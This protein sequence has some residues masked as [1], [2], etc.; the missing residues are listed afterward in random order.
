MQLI[1]T[2]WAESFEAGHVGSYV[3]EMRC[4][5]VKI[6]VKVLARFV[7]IRSEGIS[8]FIV[9]A[10][11]HEEEVG[12]LFVCSVAKCLLNHWADFSETLCNSLTF[13]SQATTT[14]WPSSTRYSWHVF[15]LFVISLHSYWGRK[16]VIMFFFLSEMDA[17]FHYKFAAAYKIFNPWP[18]PFSV[19]SVHRCP[20]ASLV[21]GPVELN[22]ET[23]VSDS[24]LQAVE[25]SF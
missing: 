11:Q 23:Q 19:C 24:H 20:C 17:L 2:F 6:T 1:K 7:F 10:W 3:L 13:L 16:H 8:G 22:G 9:V 15:S 14:T 25:A 12:W 21:N 18:D 4:S 5:W